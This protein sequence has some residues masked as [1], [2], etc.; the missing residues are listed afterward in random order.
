LPPFLQPEDSF[1]KLPFLAP[2]DLDDIIYLELR[3]EITRETG[4]DLVR[5]R[6]EGDTRSI[7]QIVDDEGLRLQP[8]TDADYEQLATEIIEQ[9]PEMADVVRKEAEKGKGREK[10]KVMW[11]VGQMMRRMENAS[12]GPAE[13]AVRRVIGV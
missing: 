7:D 8:M 13:G 4:R 10:G 12:A 6:F 1:D 3:S 9:N 2:A 5:R 11:F